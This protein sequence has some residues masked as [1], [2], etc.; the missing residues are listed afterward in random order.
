MWL[1]PLPSLVLL[2]KF[3]IIMTEYW[4]RTKKKKRRV[5]NLGK[6]CILYVI[7]MLL[8]AMLNNIF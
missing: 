7:S 4:S 6:E 2:R 8:L 3:L 1:V 5:M